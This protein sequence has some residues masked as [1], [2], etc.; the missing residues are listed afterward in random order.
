MPKVFYKC[1]P[2]WLLGHTSN[3]LPLD[4]KSIGYKSNSHLLKM[5]F[6][7]LLA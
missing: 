1:Q 3:K 5:G 6:S 2:I 4:L 7:L